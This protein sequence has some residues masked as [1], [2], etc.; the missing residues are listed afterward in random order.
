MGYRYTVQVALTE[1]NGPESEFLTDCKTDAVLLYRALRDA[2]H[3]PIRLIENGYY[4]RGGNWVA[5]QYILTIEN[6]IE[7]AG[8]PRPVE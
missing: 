2:K 4:T 1:H 6:G 8:A 3:R 7:T 5:P